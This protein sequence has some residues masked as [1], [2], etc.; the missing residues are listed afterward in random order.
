ME[1]KE[2]ILHVL[3]NYANFN[4]RARR[5]EYWYWT[6]AVTLVSCALTF[7]IRLSGDS[8][9]LHGLLTGIESL[10]SLAVLVPGLAV[11]W[12]RLHDIGKSGANWFWI[13]LPIVGIIMLLVWYCQDSQPGDNQYGPNPKETTAW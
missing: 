3:N 5:S 13:F 1:F 12:R 9:I 2:A 6:L 10:F 11:C 8:G 7:L 4:G